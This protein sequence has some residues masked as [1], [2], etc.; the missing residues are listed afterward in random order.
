MSW[1]SNF[2][3]VTIFFFGVSPPFFHSTSNVMSYTLSYAL[4]YAL[5]N[6]KLMNKFNTILP[7]YTSYV[8]RFRVY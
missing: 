6:L 2:V 5:W 1:T 4:I 7:E 3:E 8:Q